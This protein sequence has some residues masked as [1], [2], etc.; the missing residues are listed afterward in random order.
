MGDDNEIKGMTDE[1]QP[2]LFAITRDGGGYRLDRRSF[3]Q[4]VGAIVAA[5]GM[6]E[7]IYAADG[8]AGNKML[9][10][11]D[12]TA[13]LPKAHSGMV[14]SVAFSPDGGLLASGSSDKTIKLWSLPDGRLQATLDGQGNFVR[15]VAF[16]PDGRFLAT[17]GVDKTVK[18]WSL[19]DGKSH[20]T[21]EGHGNSV[22]S[23][24]FTPD[25]KLLASGDYD[26]K[27]KLWS[28]PDGK[29]QATLNGHTHF[30]NSIAFS[31]VGRLL[32]SGSL[33]K[34]VKLWSIPDGWLRATLRGHGEGVNSVAFSP[35]GRLLASCSRDKTIKLWSLSENELLTTPEGYIVKIRKMIAELLWPED[36]LQATLEGHGDRVNSIAYS[37]DGSF[38]TSGSDDKTIKLWLM[39]EGKPQATLEGHNGKVN[40]VALHPDGKLLASGDDEGCIILWELEGDRRRWVLFDPKNW[41]EQIKLT[42]YDEKGSGA[43]AVCTCN[44]IWLP[45]G[46]A[47]PVKAACVCNTI[48]V[49]PV[50]PGGESKR[51]TR[52]TERGTVCS[53]DEICTCNTVSRPST[54]GGSSGGSHYWRPS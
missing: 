13:N 32:A 2:R 5:G 19:P 36:R 44:T 9:I 17:G 21:L 54:S 34:T 20:I 26:N 6:R 23:V 11:K 38:L 30:V 3:I 33:D 42:A 31:P 10:L 41:Q 35:D 15:S 47:L 8:I 43:A 40:S 28:L 45:E 52:Q 53:C 49:G 29:L 4:A 24:V 7:S 27:I 51:D 16:S 18:L 50:K 22:M 46:A 48:V 39:P 25:G 12:S 37:R 1:E 14:N